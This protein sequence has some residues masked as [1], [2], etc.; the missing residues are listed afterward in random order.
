[1]TDGEGRY[2]I[3]G[4]TPGQRALIAQKPGM[5]LQPGRQVIVLEK[6][7]VEAKSFLAELEK[8]GNR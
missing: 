5:R 8:Q 4:L 6:F 3:A 1:M 2:E 7:D